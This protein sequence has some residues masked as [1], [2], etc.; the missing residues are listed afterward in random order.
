M[1]RGSLPR[2]QL[3]SLP[4]APAASAFCS[5]SRAPP[6][7]G[8]GAGSWRGCVGGGPRRAEPG[9][10]P[11]PDWESEA[12]IAEQAAVGVRARSGGAA[13]RRGRAPG[14]A[15]VGVAAPGGDRAARCE[16]RVEERPRGAGQGPNAAPGRRRPERSR[17]LSGGSASES[18]RRDTQAGRSRAMRAAL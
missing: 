8:S 2:S 1:P 14:G 13:R 7:R 10:W 12:A 5:P 11:Q 17:G 15:G 3:A 18:R 6:S 16:H 4:A 9:P